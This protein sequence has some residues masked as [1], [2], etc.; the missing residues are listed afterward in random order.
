MP[1]LTFNIP[2]NKAKRLSDSLASVGYVYDPT[3]QLTD[4]QQRQK[5]VEKLTID[6]WKGIV[7]NY[8]RQIA[9]ASEPN[10]TAALQS[11][12]FIGLDDVTSSTV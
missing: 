12:R 6:Y 4:N 3:S 2:N 11:A 5:F 7:F 8:E 9:I 1:I 10:D